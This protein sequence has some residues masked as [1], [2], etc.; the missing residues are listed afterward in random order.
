[1]VLQDI[2]RLADPRH[3]RVAGGLGSFG[4]AADAVE[5]RGYIEQPRSAS[6][7]N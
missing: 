5:D 2:E 6:R 4:T 7:K 3:A 1:L